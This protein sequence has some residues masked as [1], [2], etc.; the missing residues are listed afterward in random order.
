VLNN[1]LNQ[2]NRWFKINI[3]S[4]TKN[5]RNYMPFHNNIYLNDSKLK[6]DG[7]EVSRAQITKFLGELVDGLI[8]LTLFVND[9]L[10]HICVIYEV[11]NIL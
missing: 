6:I 1:E 10:K 5:K 11:K 8:I 4:L 7:L 3:L 2:M 9:I